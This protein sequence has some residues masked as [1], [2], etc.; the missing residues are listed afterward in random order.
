MTGQT[1][2]VYDSEKD[3]KNINNTMVNCDHYKLGGA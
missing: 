2:R 3:S 1:E